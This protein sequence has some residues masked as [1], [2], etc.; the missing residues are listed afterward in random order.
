[1]TNPRNMR[2]A[3]ILRGA[4]LRKGEPAKAKQ[5]SESIIKEGSLKNQSAI[6]G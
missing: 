5:I 3:T 1:M 4:Y 6:I 2:A